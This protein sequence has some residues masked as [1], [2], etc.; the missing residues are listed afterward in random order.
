MLRRYAYIDSDSRVKRGEDEIMVKGKK[1]DCCNF[2]HEF[3]PRRSLK[4]PNVPS[5]IYHLNRE[6]ADVIGEEVTL[7]NYRDYLH[8]REE[9][10]M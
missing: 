3:F 2:C 1:Y 8:Y 5:R 7:K 10:C 6:H 4:N 9:K